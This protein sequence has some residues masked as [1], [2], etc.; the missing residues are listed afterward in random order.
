MVLCSPSPPPASNLTAGSVDCTVEQ[1]LL[2]FTGACTGSRVTSNLGGFG[3]DSGAEEVRYR[4]IASHD[5][6]DVDLVITLATDQPWHPKQLE[7]RINDCLT[8]G[9][10]E[11]VYPPGTYKDCYADPSW[12]PGKPVSDS[13]GCHPNN[14]F[15][16]LQ[17]ENGQRN[18]FH[19]EIRRCCR[20]VPPRQLSYL[21]LHSRTCHTHHAQERRR[22]A[23]RA[24]SLLDVLRRL[25]RWWNG[26]G[27]GDGCYALRALLLSPFDGRRRLV[28]LSTNL[29]VHRAGECAQR[30]R[31][32]SDA[33]GR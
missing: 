16:R 14:Y 32:G 9:E 29:Q 5:G 23:V 17:F 13:S 12:L 8:D 25:G 3:P 11:N 21:H 20:R 19:F 26:V 31:P 10:L 30:G 22:L 18:T 15:G 7:H 27:F 4:Q 28:Y 33:V 24:A 6:N 2:D 1:V